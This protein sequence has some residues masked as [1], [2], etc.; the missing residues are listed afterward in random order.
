M[1]SQEWNY[2]NPSGSR[3]VSNVDWCIP[4][5]APCILDELLII[6]RVHACIQLYNGEKRVLE[7][8]M[9][10]FYFFSILCLISCCGGLLYHIGLLLLSFLLTNSLQLFSHWNDS[11]FSLIIAHMKKPDNMTVYLPSQC[12]CVRQ[13]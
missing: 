8:N 1:V 4:T 7:M 5:T 3:G 11:R 9:V 2:I 13:L 12:S 6:D 10:L